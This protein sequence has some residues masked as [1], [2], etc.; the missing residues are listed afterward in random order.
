MPPSSDLMPILPTKTWSTVKDHEFDKGFPKFARTGN[1]ITLN[2]WG[3]LR[4]VIRTNENK[5]K[6]N[7]EKTDVW[8]KD[9]EFWSTTAATKL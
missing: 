3:H 8:C 1:K 4:G 5:N 6:Y 7:D 2:G 9:I